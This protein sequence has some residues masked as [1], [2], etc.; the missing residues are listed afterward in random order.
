M[1]SMTKPSSNA[2]LRGSIT[3]LRRHL[4]QIGSPWHGG[5]QLR[6]KRVRAG[7]IVSYKDETAFPCRSQPAGECLPEVTPVAWHDSLAGL[8]PTKTRWP[9]FPPVGASLLANVCLRW[10]L[11]S[12]TIRLQASSYKNETVVPCRTWPAGSTA[13]RPRERSFSSLSVRIGM[14]CGAR[15]QGAGAAQSPA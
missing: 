11:L 5:P 9:P 15:A 8:S 2:C 12:G 13:D 4:H 3:P 6:A 1:G 10:C 14:G 7:T